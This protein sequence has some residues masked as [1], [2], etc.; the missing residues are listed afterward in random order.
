[1][2]TG[3]EQKKNKLK[4]NTIKIIALVFTPECGKHPKQNQKPVKHVPIGC[5]KLDRR[6]DLSCIYTETDVSNNIHFYQNNHLDML[7]PSPR[8]S[9]RMIPNTCNEVIKV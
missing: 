9:H 8:I 3:T 2:F 1:M 7:N 6:L 4:R 5:Q